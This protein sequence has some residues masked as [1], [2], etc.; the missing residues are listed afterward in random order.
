MG[1]EP[2]MKI[3]P[4]TN[5]REPRGFNS[6]HKAAQVHKI[7]EI[8]YAKEMDKYLPEQEPEKMRWYQPYLIVLGFIIFTCFAEAAIEWLARL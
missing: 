2:V 7:S 5:N 1:I 4:I 8:R 3:Y 6:Y